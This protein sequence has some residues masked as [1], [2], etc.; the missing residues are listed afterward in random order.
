MDEGMNTVLI[1][2]RPM[3][4]ICAPLSAVRDHTPMLLVPN[5][6]RGSSS[7]IASVFRPRKKL[8]PPVRVGPGQNVESPALKAIEIE[9][10]RI[11]DQVGAEEAAARQVDRPARRVDDVEDARRP[12]FTDEVQ[13]LNVAG[14]RRAE[15]EVERELVVRVG[16]GV[17]EDVVV[18]RGMECV[19]RQ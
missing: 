17:D 15:P 1:A 9:E 14:A 11:V 7:A 2:G 18:G 4:S 5:T 16:V 13:L 3:R 8:V 12:R 10:E 6:E 19:R